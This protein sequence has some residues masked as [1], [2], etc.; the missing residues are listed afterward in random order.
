VSQL[1]SEYHP[2]VDISATDLIPLILLLYVDDIL[3]FS[4]SAEQVSE[5]KKLLH[6]EYKM[7][8]LGPTRQFLGLEIGHDHEN[9]IL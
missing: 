1:R 4:E 5:V 9:R 3:L 8:D 6:A 2:N 7:T